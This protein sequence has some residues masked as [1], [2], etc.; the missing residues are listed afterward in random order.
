MGSGVLRAVG[1]STRPLYF[2]IFT[3]VLNIALDLLFVL[4]FRL[5]IAGAAIATVISQ[6]LSAALILLLLTRT[7]DIYR[8][9]WRE[10]GVDLPITSAVYR[11]L[12]E[13][14]DAREELSALFTRS[15]KEEF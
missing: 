3:S 13:N 6:A 15:I 11:I 9:S 10:L 14:G 1:D 7:R 8:L 12:F 4:V 2:L 5:G